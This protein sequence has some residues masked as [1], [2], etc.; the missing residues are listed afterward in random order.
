MT[1]ARSRRALAGLGL[2]AGLA[3]GPAMA[4]DTVQDTR[5][6]LRD[7]VP[8]AKSGPTG[9]TL[10]LSLRA[11]PPAGRTRSVPDGGTVEIGDIVR[12]CFSTD[13]EGTVTLWSHGVE[14]QVARILPNAFTGHAGDEALSVAAGAEY[15]IDSEGLSR[16][17]EPVT[18]PER[19]WGLRVDGP[20]G[21]A[22]VYLHWTPPGSPNLPAGAFL[23][24]DG[25]A[26]AVR[27]DDGQGVPSVRQSVTYEIR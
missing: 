9:A 22:E 3:A 15:C 13:T 23:D 6:M 8:V 24:V 25:L 27:E 18:D 21:R 17:G 10:D 19:P 14:G 1:R 12:V 2:A 11:I 5:P 20:R 16:D 7:L 26:K 4:Q